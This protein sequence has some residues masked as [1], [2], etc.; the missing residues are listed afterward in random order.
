MPAFT[1][2]EV[3]LSLVIAIRVTY[4]LPG[5]LCFF[6]L[7]PLQTGRIGEEGF[8]R[9]IRH[10]GDYIL[11]GMHLHFRVHYTNILMYFQS[12]LAY[13][14]VIPSARM[15]RTSPQI[16]PEAEAR[17]HSEA[18]NRTTVVAVKQFIARCSNLLI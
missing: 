2:F 13:S 3:L 10:S 9:V 4:P 11:K 1:I 17:S 5:L 7:P 8:T 14:I 18:T 12:F 15:G 16:I 6:F